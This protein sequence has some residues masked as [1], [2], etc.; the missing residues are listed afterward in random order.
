MN[1]SKV[2]NARPLRGFI[3]ALNRVAKSLF[4]A[5]VHCRAAGHR[6]C[7]RRGTRIAATCKHRQCDDHCQTKA[8]NLFHIALQ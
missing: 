6:V 4:H 8:K 2:R 5:L 1:L 7:R 3:G